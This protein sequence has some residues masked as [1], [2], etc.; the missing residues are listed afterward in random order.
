MSP[1]LLNNPL[2]IYLLYRPFFHHPE[3]HPVSTKFSLR[4]LTPHGKQSIV[5]LS[6]HDNKL[7]L[8]K[9]AVLLLQDI[10]KPVA[11]L[12]ICGPYRTGKSYFLSRLLGSPDAFKVGHITE[13]CTHGAWMGT[14]ALECEEFVLLLLDTEGTDVIGES[15]SAGV[16]NLLVVTTLLSSCFIYNSTSVPRS[17]D[18]QKMRYIQ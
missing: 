5:L 12:T 18:L 13:C 9:E 17:I 8:N 11:I 10:K 16:L 15:N 7:K 14:T 2:L 4:K 1:S 3:T 6:L